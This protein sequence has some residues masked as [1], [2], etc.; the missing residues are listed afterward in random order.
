[1]LT[2]ESAEPL[3]RSLLPCSSPLLCLFVFFVAILPGPCLLSW[4]Q[5]LDSPGGI[6]YDDST[7]EGGPTMRNLLRLSLAAVALLAPLSRAGEPAPNTLT[8]KEKADGWRLLFDGKTTHG[9]HAFRGKDVP[10]KWKVLDGALVVS[11]KN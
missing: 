8:E 3:P 1:M 6:R 4:S 2:P 9:W 7:P 5:R 11:S 10:N